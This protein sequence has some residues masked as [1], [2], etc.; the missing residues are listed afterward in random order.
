[1]GIAINLLT[2]DDRYSLNKIEAELGTEISPIPK[3]I[4]K[5]LYVADYQQEEN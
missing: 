3:N 5:N 4:E 2:Y 1:M